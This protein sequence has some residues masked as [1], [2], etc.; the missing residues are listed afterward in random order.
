MSHLYDYGNKGSSMHVIENNDNHY[1]N[2]CQAKLNLDQCGNSKPH[3]EDATSYRFTPDDEKIFGDYDGTSCSNTSAYIDA[4]TYDCGNDGGSYCSDARSCSLSVENLNSVS[5][6]GI[7]HVNISNTSDEKY[8]VNYGQLPIS[9]AQ[10]QQRP[11]SQQQQQPPS[12]QQQRQTPP[13][14]SGESIDSHESSQSR[15]T[16]SDRGDDKNIDGSNN[17]DVEDEKNTYPA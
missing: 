5:N 7:K 13:S 3:F 9:Q 4:N 11:P 10:H 2:F 1:I 15:D 16:D 12:Q 6:D 17:Y 8:F 14:Q